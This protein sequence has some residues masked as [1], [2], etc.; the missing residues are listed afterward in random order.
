MATT[1]ID[2]T[3]D[4]SRLTLQDALDLAIRIE[5]EAQGRY[6]GFTKLVGGRYAGDAS[7]MFRMMASYEARHRTELAERRAKLFGAAP[8]RISPDAVEDVEAPDVTAPRVFMSARQAMEVALASEEKAYGF[9]TAA[10]EHVRD[11]GVRELFTELQGEELKHQRLVRAEI[12]KLPPGPDLE[13][14]DA[15]EPGSDAG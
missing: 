9:F 2:S 15:D 14:E 3:I 8:V 1:T 13:E 5:E 12:E 11:P 7:D 4:F 10:L 6:E